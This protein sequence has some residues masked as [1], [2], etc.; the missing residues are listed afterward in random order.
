MALRIWPHNDPK[1]S[2]KKEIHL[3]MNWWLKDCILAN[4]SKTTYTYLTLF[5]LLRGKKYDALNLMSIG[6]LVANPHTSHSLQKFYWYWQRFWAVKMPKLG[7][8]DRGWLLPSHCLFSVGDK[9]L[10]GLPDLTNGM[11]HDAFLW[12][13]IISK[14]E[15]WNYFL[16]AL[17]FLMCSILLQS[18]KN[19]SKT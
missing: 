1:M 17:P 13:L 4:I 8:K 10:I 15:T 12:R 5:L 16:T 9:A 18:L 7:M 3:N 6:L 2:G 11:R 14:W 19:Q